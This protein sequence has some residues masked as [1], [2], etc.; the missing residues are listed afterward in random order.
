MP[1]KLVPPRAGKTPYWYIRGTY[2][3]RYVDQSART[4]E[5]RVATR[6][7][8]RIKAEIEEGKF[9]R[10]GEATFL[11]AAVAYMEAGGEK[12]FVK[13][14]LDHFKE[15]ALSSID[16][17]AIDEA[18]LALYPDATPA[19]RNRQ[20]YTVV[21]AIL[22]QAG[23]DRKLKRPKGAGGKQRTEWLW[24]EQAFALFKAA[25]EIDKEFGLFLRVLCYTGMRL[26]E[27]LNLRWE[28]VRLG[29][30]F[31]YVPETKTGT[32][33]PVF[34]PDAARQAIEGLGARPARR[35]V[36][37]FTKSGRLY[38]LLRAA[39]GRWETSGETYMAGV[40]FHT[41][42]HTWAT[43]MRRYGGLDTRGL[44]GTGAWKDA[45]SVRRYEHVVATEEAMRATRLPVEEPVDLDK[46]AQ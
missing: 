40:T 15:H 27:A 14:L 44:I 1:L 39:L 31:A 7:L 3:G 28:D 36:F 33:R 8:Q 12:R 18:A 26:S 37:R 9:A 30:S 32:P 16:Q 34:L 29:E 6:E 23:M 13:P 43:W 21:S 4:P 38:G 41:F 2:L 42:R 25:D 5:R 11:T 10:R 20:V 17:A 45:G 46:D 35:R 19:T 24:P 22:K